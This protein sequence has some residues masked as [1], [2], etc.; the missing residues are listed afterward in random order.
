MS[1][2]EFSQRIEAMNA[3][4]E[5]EAFWEKRNAELMEARK[6][7]SE[8]LRQLE[9]ARLR[10]KWGEI[11]DTYRQP[12]VP[13]KSKLSA[14]TVDFC[15]HWKPDGGHGIGISGPTGMGKTRILVAVLH[16]YHKNNPWLYL[17]ATSLS[18]AVAEQWHDDW[19]IAYEAERILKLARRVRILLIDDLYN[20]RAS[21]ASSV[22]LL[23][24][25]EHRTANLRPILWTTNSTMEQLEARHG[26]RGA[27]ITRRLTEFCETF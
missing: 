16:R 19:K 25:V 26:I 9:D 13:S 15:R 24:L 6:R 8:E 21:D 11:P 10:K 17:P 4:L 23:E 20:E 2:D 1:G 7:A 12:F 18:R 3:L 22:E 14:A 5:D 27:P